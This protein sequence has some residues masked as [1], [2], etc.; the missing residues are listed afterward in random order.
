M[1]RCDGFVTTD[2]LD[3]IRARSSAQRESSAVQS[4]AEPVLDPY[5]PGVTAESRPHPR[6][7]T[8][9]EPFKAAHEGYF[10]VLGELPLPPML[11]AF[12]AGGSLAGKDSQE[13][14][15]T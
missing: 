7:P 11:P 8:A 5:L 6:R 14:S 9:I 13:A 2:C 1:S 12:V 15:S 4:R 10:L 3:T